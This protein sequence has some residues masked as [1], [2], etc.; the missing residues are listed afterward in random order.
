[1]AV[2]RLYS[3]PHSELMGSGRWNEL[4]RDKAVAYERLLNEACP[5]CGTLREDWVDER[6]R[7]LEEPVLAAVA[8]HC[9]GCEEVERVNKA[10]P[11]MA[12]GTYVVIIPF[13]ALE[14]GDDDMYDRTTDPVAL[15]QMQKEAANEA[16]GMAGPLVR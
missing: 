14:E 1:M 15:E 6:G 12:R 5:K 11:K 10:I 13:A 16:T 8:K 2:C 7:P 9:Y 3:I 4:D